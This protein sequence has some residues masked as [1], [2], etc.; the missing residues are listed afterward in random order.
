M[1]IRPLTP[2]DASAFQALRLEALRGSP[3]AFASSYEEERDLPLDLVGSRLAKTPDSCVLGAFDGSRL[4]GCIGLKREAHRKL[5]HKAFIWGMYVAPEHRGRG[6]GRM[7][8]EEVLRLAESVP[9]LRQITLSVNSTN[10]EAKAT[11][12]HLGFRS[13]GV[14]PAAMCIEESFH[15]EIHMVRF[16]ERGT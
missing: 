15:D 7:L 13:Y 4:I 9:G 10:S 6:L 11:Y 16:L 3:T 8:V 14:E 12:E 1:T 2:D 5:A